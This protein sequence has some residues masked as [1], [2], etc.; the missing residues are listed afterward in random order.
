MAAFVEKKTAMTTFPDN[1]RSSSLEMFFRIAVLKYLRKLP[2]KHSWWSVLSSQIK[3]NII[4]R[5]FSCNFSNCGWL[6]I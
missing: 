5:M 6:F 3:K 1:F 2:R 4:P